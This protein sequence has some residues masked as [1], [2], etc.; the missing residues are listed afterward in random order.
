MDMILEEA[1]RIVLEG[2]DDAEHKDEEVDAFTSIG[3][4]K[5]DAVM[6]ATDLMLNG[7]STEEM[8]HVVNLIKYDTTGFVCDHKDEIVDWVKKL[9]MSWNE[10]W[11]RL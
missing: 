3:I 4:S 9:F 6:M 1:Y 10:L 11:R 8:L 7:F 5:D 2:A